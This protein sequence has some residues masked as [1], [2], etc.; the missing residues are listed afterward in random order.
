M[1]KIYVRPL[2][3]NSTTPY[4]EL[5]LF[6]GEVVELTLTNKNDEAFDTVYTPFTQ[7]FNVPATDKNKQALIHYFEVNYMKTRKKFLEAVITLN[8][9]VY[10][11]GKI[12]IN[13]MQYVEKF[14]TSISLNFYTALTALKDKIGEDKLTDLEYNVNT[15][16]WNAENVYRNASGQIPHDDI[17]VPLIS[18][19]R[20]WNYKG[21]GSGD[22]YDSNYP[23]TQDELRPALRLSKVMDAIINK[24]D[25]TIDC[26]LFGRPEYQNLFMY[27]NNN[28]SEKE[29]IY[30]LP[31]TKA[32]S[33]NTST[34][35]TF[36]TAGNGIR[37]SNPNIVGNHNMTLVVELKNVVNVNTG[38]GWDDDISIELTVMDSANIERVYEFTEWTRQSNNGM[39]FVITLDP[40]QFGHTMR[41]NFR[42]KSK[43]PLSIQ[44]FNAGAIMFGYTIGSSS[45][46]VS[47]NN[48]VPN[49]QANF[50]IAT[51]ISSMKVSDFLTSFFKTFNI[52]VL[53]KQSDVYSMEWLTPQDIIDDVI[54]ITNYVDWNTHD[55]TSPTLYKTIKFT[56]E[57]SSLFRN[58][59]YKKTAANKE[60]GSEVYEETETDN[61]E[62]YEIETNFQVMNYFIL[63]G[64]TLL[65]SY[66]WETNGEQYFG[67][68][69]C[70]IFYFNGYEIVKDPNFFDTN[71]FFKY[72]L[73][74]QQP[75]V[76]I[77]QYAKVSN[78]DT[79][80]KQSLTWDITIDPKTLQPYTKSLFKSYY[81][82]F[83]EN[84][85][86]NNSRKFR[87]DAYLPSNII[88]QIKITSTLIIEDMRFYVDEIKMDL[89][90][91]KSELTL[92]YL[93]Y[94]V[95][96]VLPYNIYPVNMLNI[97]STT[98]NSITVAFNGSNVDAPQYITGHTLRYKRTNETVW[99]Y[100]DI[101]AP[102]G[103]N[104]SFV[105]TI[106]PLYMNAGY[107][108]EVQAYDN[109]GKVSSWKSIVGTT[110]W[111]PTPIEIPPSR[112]II[113]NIRQDLIEFII[114]NPSV[115]IGTFS[116]DLLNTTNKN[117]INYK[118]TIKEP[119][120]KV[121][122]LQNSGQGIYEG[123][124]AFDTV[125]GR[126]ITPIN[127]LYVFK[128]KE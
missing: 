25:L 73:S 69:Q 84:I 1:I 63:N 35:G 4:V 59:Q 50:D 47:P 74:D 36:I 75:A 22:I 37:Y 58:V 65:T 52:R 116:V 56:H 41:F 20:A 13:T 87:F 98:V 61:S 125:E 10:K 51:S 44:S 89:V 97:F 127:E 71:V 12:Q 113:G 39:T 85:Y 92:T 121:I 55:I 30:N 107:N 24:Y 102:N 64:T 62:A 81:Q 45:S 115:Y 112:V 27:L 100:V 26:P 17:I 78:V 19:K 82:D 94:K 80:S 31:V 90:T 109:L 14:S 93:E 7:E 11:K 66:A 68:D 99:T 8:E 9:Q 128:D 33:A 21:G 108:I 86:G 120:E 46:G 118:Q 42:L 6:E 32:W 54:N 38:W 123:T 101:P 48:T 88:E 96:G 43:V 34:F 83:I 119:K 117:R 126:S 103:N 91:G 77:A 111:Q 95:N 124:I 76:Q 53:E 105:Y 49:Q 122:I 79:V 3:S 5:D 29:F 70:I 104:M 114:D 72:R 67:Q 15:F 106:Q 18:N 57:E 23:I 2:N 28:A 16:I 60:F 110:Q 40:R